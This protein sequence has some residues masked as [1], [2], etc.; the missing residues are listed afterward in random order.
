MEFDLQLFIT[1]QPLHFPQE[2]NCQ[3]S[4][5]LEIIFWIEEGRGG[6]Q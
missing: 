4:N 5:L 2:H 1:T 6:D 3:Q